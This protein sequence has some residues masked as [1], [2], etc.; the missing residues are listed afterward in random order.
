VGANLLLSGSAD[1]GGDVDEAAVVDDPLLGAAANLPSRHVVI[2]ISAGFPLSLTHACF[3]WL[4][5]HLLLLLLGLD[6]GGLRLDLTGTR[7]RSVNLSHTEQSQQST[8]AR[9]K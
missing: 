5:A 1:L 8:A 7:E 9:R 3:D 6:L 2:S 4:L